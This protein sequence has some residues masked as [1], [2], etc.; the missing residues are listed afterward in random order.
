M[1]KI[2]KIAKLELSLLIYSPVVWLVFPIF[3]I[4]CGISFLGI[5]Q[6]ARMSLSLG[7]MNGEALTNYL[8][9]GMRGL[10]KS[11][12]STLY[13]YIPILTMGLM[14]RE[15]S[16]GSIKL[17]LSSP[18]KLTQ[19]ILG[20]YLAAVFL[21]LGFIIIL[22]IYAIVGAF[23][24]VNVD[25][26]MLLSG[27]FG[28]F[29]LI[30]TYAAI[31]LFTS[32]L[33]N[34]QIVAA[35]AT[36]AIFTALRY[37]G[38]IGQSIDFIR[39]LTYFLS[40]GGRTENLTAG[41]ITTK[42]IFYY[43][44]IIVS[45]LIFSILYL[46]NQR[47][48]K[49][50]TVKAGRYVLVIVIALVF[51]YI[52]SRPMFTGYLDATAGKSQTMTENGQQIVKKLDGEIKVTT[53]VNMFAPNGFSLL[54][55]SRNSD[56][57][58]MEGYKRFIPGM[59]FN[60]V[61]YY[62]DLVDTTLAYYKMGSK[63]KGKTIK[64]LAE[65]F[66]E[67]TEIPLNTFLT[68]DEINKQIDLKPEGYLNIRKLEYKGKTAFLRFFPMEQYPYALESEWMAAIKRLLG[69]YAKVT[70]L[71]GNN[72]SDIINNNDRGYREISTNLIKRSALINQGF[73]IDTLNL[74]EKD[75]APDVNLLV[76][77]DPTVAFS[78]LAIQRLTAYIDRGGNLLVTTEPGRQAIINPVLTKLGLQIKPGMLIR[79]DKD[80][81]IDK[82]TS[83][84][85]P[86]AKDIDAN[87]D[88]FIEFKLSQILKTAGAINYSDS[89]AFVI[90]P[91]FLSPADGW[92]KVGPID[93]NAP[94]MNFNA[95]DGD[96]KGVFPVSVTMSRKINNKE[97][98]I[99]VSAD[100]DFL[101][102]SV[103]NSS[104][105][106]INIMTLNGIFRWLVYGKFPV[107][108]IRPA[109]K[110]VTLKVSKEQ[111]NLMLIFFKYILPAI[112]MAIGIVI[113][114][115]RRRN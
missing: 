29:L 74:N 24:I 107:D 101:S 36:L 79:P 23:S 92:N 14:S 8:F 1:R 104:P 87:F 22:G 78:S 106:P 100:A 52:S 81:S 77:G 70:F 10:F 84:F 99:I 96:Q 103:F 67:N 28:L 83:D 115:K 5:L 37:V 102:N 72:E 44:T 105:R 38:S 63:K 49:P 54:P 18:V 46:K 26:G 85:A 61:Y 113:L 65:D 51:G 64:Q 112:M 76:L 20:K 88:K 86:E 12:P 97:Q 73:D 59:K 110:D 45:F 53:Y 62:Q 95:A 108:E 57:S 17:L 32:C 94:V 47:E 60:Y 98:R 75:I 42:D 91:L 35:I 111:I 82:I 71:T 30:C 40:L 13:L 15:T 4:L 48:L 25:T 3:L 6:Q 41:L 11:I 56:L 50:W 9:D 114:F 93:M 58:V 16:S 33:T 69:D 68:P 89:G 55:E 39:D 109:A 34:Y 31:G 21:G 43:L 90:K 80:H 7:Y 27:L 19:I 2:F 66:A